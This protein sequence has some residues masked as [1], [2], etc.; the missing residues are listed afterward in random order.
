M[1]EFIQETPKPSQNPPIEKH[2]DVVIIGGGLSGLCAAVAS[3]R[4]GANTCLVQDRAV[5]GGNASSETRMHV[6][7]ASCHWGKTNAS[8]T[9]ILMELQLENKY[10]NDSYNF[11]IWDGVMWNKVLHTKNLDS[12]MNTTMDRVIADGDE[13]QAVE[14]YQMTTE[15]RY[16]FT[17]DIY[18]DC[19]GHGTL[20]YFAGAEYA[21]GRESGLQYDE[22]SAPEKEDGFTM[23]NTIYFC[24]QDMGHP[25]KFTKPDWAPSLDDS[26]FAHRYHG[27]VITY[28]TDDA[29]VVL[30]EGEDYE[31]HA[32][33]LVEKYDVQSGYWWIELGGDWDDI[34]KD[35]ED[36]RWELYKIIYG[37]WDHIKNYE[38]HGAENYELIWVG[39]VSG[40]RESRRLIGDY[41]LTENDIREDT[42]VHRPDSVAFGGWPMDEHTAGG[43]A[44]KGDI[45]SM[46]RNFPG[47]YSIPYGCYCSKNIKNLMMAGRNISASKVAM[48]STRVMGT[49]AI[50]GQ[51]AGT[52]A[53][54]ATKLGLNPTDFGKEHVEDLRQELLKD[55]CYIIDC[56]NQDP[57]DIAR[58][59]KVSA[60]SEKSGY[61]AVKVINGIARNTD[62][63]VNEWVSDGISSNGETLS[64][65]FDKTSI[66]Q[67]RVTLDP[68]L[69][70]ERCIT[71]SKAFI[72]K[73]PIGVPVQLVKDFTVKAYNNDDV[74]W[75]T[76]VEGN[77]QRHLIFDLPETVE[78]DKVELC[79][80]STNGD[81]DVRVFEVRIY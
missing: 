15:N 72:E 26:F 4:H 18:M 67:V 35:A 19:T 80:T 25:V 68:D 17:A 57:N 16:K 79:F 75:E 46:V 81:D 23:G 38:D 63:E 22:K 61:E 24:A 70:E 71:V 56:K 29:V 51:A 33:Q 65:E 36:I 58:K 7:G 10:L 41:V 74:V 3:A 42:R 60:S 64:F 59:S 5:Y 66:K 44:A 34:I 2:Y 49:C 53:A 20:G 1:R 77:Y 39:N 55:D 45:P 50:G 32:D 47:L 73:Q 30:K 37:V 40:T 52:A 21:I 8:E 69:S 62:T 14:C 9:G 11:S 31:D 78:A 43:F 76:K 13:I 54:M 6:S 12:Y 48:G 27:N 28:H